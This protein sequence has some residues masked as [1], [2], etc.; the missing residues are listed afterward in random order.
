MQKLY[1]TQ[2]YACADSD[3]KGSGPPT[4]KSQK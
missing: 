1:V 2:S 3:G 4:E